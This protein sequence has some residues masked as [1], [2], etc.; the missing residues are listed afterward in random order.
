MGT[1]S[2]EQSGFRGR[3]YTLSELP[4]QRPPAC[5]QLL[6]EGQLLP[7]LHVADRL[8]VIATLEPWP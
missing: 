6:L 7:H 8:S 4:R 1:F 3:L 5:G 2:S